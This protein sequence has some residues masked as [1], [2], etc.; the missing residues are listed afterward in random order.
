[1]GALLTG[2]AL[3]SCASAPSPAGGGG[4][5]PPA[6]FASVRAFVY[7]CDA[8]GTR[9]FFQKDG[10]LARGIINGPGVL[11]TE[12]QVKRLLPALTTE[13]PRDHRTACFLP[14]HAFVFY[15]AGGR[16]V[17]HTE[18]CFTCTIQQSFPAGLPGHIQFQKVWD[19][20]LEAGVPCGEGSQ[21]YK[22]L[23]KAR[24]AGR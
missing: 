21:F 19:I 6:K 9:H 1:M 14:H 12:A 15:D 20:L 16:V 7:D 13:T 23:F 2:A 22:D 3:V 17:A 10:A 5:W 18:V 11:L 24:P 4:A 8:D